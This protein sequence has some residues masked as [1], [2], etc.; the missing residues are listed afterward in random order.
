MSN[1]TTNRAGYEQAG[2]YLGAGSGLHVVRALA[3]GGQVVRVVFSAEPKHRSASALDDGR[4]PANYDVTITAGTGQRLQVVG[5]LP[6][7]IAWQ[8]YGLWASS[9][10]ALDVQTDRPLVVGL[11]YLVTVKTPLVSALGEAVGSPYA[12]AFVGASRPTRTRQMR[13]KTGLADFASDPFTGGIMV[14]SAG[15]WSTHEG[16]EGTRKRIWRIALTPKGSFSF[17]PNF[18]LNH[19]IKKPATLSVLTG[20]RTDLRQQ[21]LQQPD[22]KASSTSVVMDARGLLNLT[23]NIQTQSGQ[24]I[25]DTVKATPDGGIIVP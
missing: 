1:H 4:N 14:D 13:R 3:V 8:A 20:L 24:S 11:Q 16:T 2:E 19:D 10:F 9:E 22:V 12:A 23:I 7:V 21:I 5:V 17:L 6:D 15:D 18:G 25:S